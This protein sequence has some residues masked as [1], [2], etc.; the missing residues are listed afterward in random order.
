MQQHPD[1]IV[2]DFNNQALTFEERCAEVERIATLLLDSGH[3]KLVLAPHQ[4]RRTSAQNDFMW[5]MVRQIGQFIGEDSERAT[6]NM[7][8]VQ[9]YGERFKPVRGKVVQVYP[10]TSKFTK[11]QMC[12][13][14][15]WMEKFARVD[16]NCPLK[17]PDGYE[18]YARGH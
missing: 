17:V 7:L 14:L 3:S 4:P 15:D 11:K 8:L 10:Q 2:F 12:E 18:E 13:F 16:L 6:L 1:G 9:K 5:P